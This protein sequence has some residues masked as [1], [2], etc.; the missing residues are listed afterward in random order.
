MLEHPHDLDAQIRRAIAL[1]TNRP[2]TAQEIEESRDFIELLKRDEG[3]QNLE[4]LQTFCLLALN[5][6]EFIYVD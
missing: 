6:N 2:A 1:S 3:V 5:L 4:S